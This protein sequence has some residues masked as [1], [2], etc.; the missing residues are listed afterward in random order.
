MKPINF[1]KDS[2]HWR[3]AHKY[4]GAEEEYSTKE[5]YERTGN[6][7]AGYQGDICDYMQ[8]MIGGFCLCFLITAGLTIALFPISDSITWALAYYNNGPLEVGYGPVWLT[9]EIAVA[10]F[11]GSL[12]LYY[13]WKS[14]RDHQAYLARTAANAGTYVEPVK[15]NSIMQSIHRRIKDKTCFTVTVQ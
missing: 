4:G 6:P 7:R 10:A 2:W 3:L 5:E 11:I 1:S 13:T 8:H 15:K 9:C 14:E 12:Y